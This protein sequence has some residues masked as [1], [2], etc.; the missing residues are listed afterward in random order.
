[1]QSD[2]EALKGAN[3]FSSLA[4]EPLAQLATMAQRR[5]FERGERIFSAGD[6]G[7]TLFVIR[8]G[9]VSIQAVSNGGKDMTLAELR[10]GEAFG[11]LALLDG[12]P[13]SATAVALEETECVALSRDAFLGLVE[14]NTAAMRGVLR[15]LSAI[16]R[17]MNDR[18]VEV[19]SHSYAER[20][21]KELHR[22]VL[23][24]GVQTPAGWLI[25]R[26]LT[27]DQLAS[28]VG[29]WQGEVESLMARLQYEGIVLVV[30]DSV[31]VA[32]PES[33]AGA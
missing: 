11:D 17:A 21:G 3:I 18:L 1:M 13:R 7:T 25:D 19:G 32:R 31:T 28:L 15:S 6:P 23:E 4:D 12:E 29:I 14:S 9:R 22:L 8:S 26:P 2:L 5:Q 20:L 10:P 16:I 27:M 24:H 33:L 30:G